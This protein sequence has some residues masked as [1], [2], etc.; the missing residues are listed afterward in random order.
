M[1]QNGRTRGRTFHG[2]MDRCRENQGWTTA[3]SNMS[4][5]DRKDQGEYSPEQACFCWFVRHELIRH[6]WRELV[7]IRASLWFASDAV[8][9]FSEVTLFVML[10]FVFL[11][12]L[13]LKP[14]PFVQSFFDMHAP[15]Q[16]H[17]VN[18][19]KCFASKYFV[20]LQVS[21]CVESRL[22]CMLP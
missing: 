10:H 15:R 1:A 17:A 20:P 11:F 6:K 4:E 9:Y 19:H 5:R 21:L 18:K 3:C 22:Y 13:S 8:L 16:P 14:G 7:F 12:L 2:E